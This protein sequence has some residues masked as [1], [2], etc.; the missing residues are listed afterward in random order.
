MVPL[1]LAELEARLDRIAWHE[2]VERELRERAPPPRPAG[3]EIERELRACAASVDSALLDT[4][5]NEDGY[6]VWALRLALF[7]EPARAK[8]RARRH[9][10]SADWEVRC[11]A[12]TIIGG[13]TQR[14]P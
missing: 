8:R 6:L 14:R 3:P 4:L 13:V 2:Q 12:R 1:T 11:W 10:D 5:E 9:L 7:V